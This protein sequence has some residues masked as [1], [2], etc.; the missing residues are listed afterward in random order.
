[1][2]SAVI[3]QMPPG[4]YSACLAARPSADDGTSTRSPGTECVD[5]VL[6]PG[7]ELVLTLE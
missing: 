5:G 1:M 4:A 3:P 7:G 2:A 6:A